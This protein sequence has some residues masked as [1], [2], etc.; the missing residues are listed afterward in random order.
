MVGGT[1]ALIQGFLCSNWPVEIPVFDLCG[2]VI[3][4][5]KTTLSHEANCGKVN[6]LGKGRKDSIV[7][8][9]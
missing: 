7:G 4:V 3:T 2:V 8:G 5:I 6:I 9:G 1:F